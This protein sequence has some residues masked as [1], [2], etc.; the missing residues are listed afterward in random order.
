[1]HMHRA[2]RRVVRILR[3]AIAL[4]NPEDPHEP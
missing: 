1:M 4:K 2:L 3:L